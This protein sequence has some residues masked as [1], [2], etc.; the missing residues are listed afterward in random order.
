MFAVHVRQFEVEQQGAFQAES[1]GVQKDGTM[2][3]VDIR[4]TVFEFKGHKHIVAVFRD[5]SERK[6][7]EEELQLTNRQL[8]ISEQALRER[9]AR[10]GAIFQGAAVGMSLVDL[11]GRAL[12]S[13]R[14]LQ[15]MLGYS[16]T[17]LRKKTFSEFIHPSDRSP[18]LQ[19]FRDL[20]Q[21]KC[22]HYQIETRYVRK[23][24]SLMWVRVTASL[25]R[26]DAG[27]PNYII[28][29]VEDITEQKRAKESLLESE[30][31]YRNLFENMLSG[32]AYHQVVLDENDRPVDYVFLEVNDAFEKLTGLK[33]E[34]V[35]GRK[36]SELLPGIE[37]S[38][39]DWIETYGKV[40]LTGKEIEFDQY[41]EA[42]GRWFSVSAYSSRKGYFA[43]VF[44]DIT[45]RRLLEEELRMFTVDLERSN[46]ELEQFAGVV[47]QDFQEPLSQI[48][49]SCDHLE[50]RFR[51]I[52]DEE[53]VE[54]VRKICAGAERMQQLIEDLLVYSRVETQGKPFDSI[55]LQAPVQ[56][57]LNKL[58]AVI[59]Q[60][61][62]VV[63]MSSLPTISGDEN[64]LE[65]LFEHLI[66]NALKFRSTE[67]PVVEISCRARGNI[68]EITVTDNGIGIDLS[69]RERIF[70]MFQKLHNQDEYPGKGVGLSFSKRIV[71]RHGGRIWV[72]SQLGRGSVFHITIPQLT[73]EVLAKTTPG[74]SNQSK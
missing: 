71:E 42:L 68:W 28:N 22:N 25:V 4:G 63:E 29:M 55:N 8:R 48:S 50:E 35:I 53:G 32:F 46:R 57:A 73:K 62:A 14:V 66:G 2:I 49:H 61:S 13:N 39:F 64:Q 3:D 74:H 15:E 31:K 58:G 33:R 17:E 5:I 1:V 9:E 24:D 52:P 72:E 67:P 18:S 47:S 54:V 26:G 38:D 27:K 30:A 21:G 12:E 34:D 70:G 7:A 23:D 59:N 43:T 56:R 20:T 65:Q 45:E 41:S 11:G 10:L 40:A 6:W 51:E 36:V 60:S 16:R 19:I 37:N 69:N 44:D